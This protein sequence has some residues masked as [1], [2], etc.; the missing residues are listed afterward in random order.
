MKTYCFDLDNTLC[1][2]VGSNYENSFPIEERITEVNNLY[3]LGEYIIIHTARGMSKYNGN[4]SK[5]YD[6]GFELTKRQLV[7]WGVKHHQLIMG[8]PSYDFFVDDKASNSEDFFKKQDSKNN[9]KV[10]IVAGAFDVI[11]PGYISMFKECR[12]Y[13]DELVVFLNIDP[14]KEHFN[15]L[16][17]VLSEKE[18]V[19]TLLALKYINAVYPYRKEQGLLEYL[20]KYKTMYAGDSNSCNLIRFLGDDYKDRNYTGKE[21]NIPI[22]FIDRSHGWTTTQFKEKIAEQIIVRNYANKYIDDLL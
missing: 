10:G 18:R 20:T 4:T 17:P 8:K 14:S 1:S 6:A 9:C 2:T 15:K 3:E 16:S 22:H 7:E 12:A 13:C 11:H 5:V 21:L 19:E